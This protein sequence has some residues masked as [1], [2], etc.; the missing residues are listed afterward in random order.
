MYFF[1]L[2]AENTFA[3]FDFVHIIV[4]V[5]S[6]SLVILVVIKRKWIFDFENKNKLGI[7]LGIILLFLDF[8][9]YVWKW[10][11]GVQLYFPI[12][13]HLCSW[14]TYLVAMS[15]IT[16]NKA[17]FQFSFYYGV[18]GGLLS[19]LVPE[20]G[21]YSFDHMRFYQFFLLHAL[22]IIGP[23]YQYFAYKMK[24]SVKYMG[25]T[26]VLMFAQA[27]LAV[28]VNNLV[29][30]WSGERANMMFVFEPPIPLPIQSPWYLFIFAILF[31]GIWMGIR[32]ILQLKRLSDS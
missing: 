18:I 14:A 5:I 7:I 19:L 29:G 23:L 10:I 16:R 8:S 13:M 27:A 1:Q 12:P 30:I 15:L 28:W 25:Y 21:G 31:F 22:I 32:G 11:N 9:F 6:F 20:F 4:L 24:L 17:L 3:T 2:Q 26:L